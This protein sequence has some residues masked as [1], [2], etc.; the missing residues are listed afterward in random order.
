VYDETKAVTDKIS[1]RKNCP[2]MNATGYRIPKYSEI[3][4]E[5]QVVES[6]GIEKGLPP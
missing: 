6:K 3:L 4:I 2:N 5:T 1:E